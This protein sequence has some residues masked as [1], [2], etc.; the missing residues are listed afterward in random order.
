MPTEESARLFT[1]NFD[2]HQLDPFSIPTALA[3]LL[4]FSPGAF[5]YSSADSDEE[6]GDAVS[7][8]RQK[9]LDNPG[10]PR[11]FGSPLWMAGEHFLGL[12]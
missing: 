4:L 2:L 12:V 7:I 11:G 1:S 10:R 6:V 8:R 5:F 3:C 9:R